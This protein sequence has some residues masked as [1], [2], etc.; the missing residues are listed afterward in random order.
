MFTKESKKH[1]FYIMIFFLFIVQSILPSKVFADDDS[2]TINTDSIRAK[3]V[4]IVS[5]KKET[6][7][8]G[9]RNIV[10]EDQTL[11][12]QILSGKHE[13]ENV[14]IKNTVDPSKQGNLVS[15]ISIYK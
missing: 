11:K 8:A 10:V 6:V 1:F 4:Q 14:I 15:G 5:T 7:N 13:G 3:V 2:K 12:I 9:D